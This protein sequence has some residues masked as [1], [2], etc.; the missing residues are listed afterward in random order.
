M[1][2]D[3]KSTMNR[4][5]YIGGS[6]IP[7]MLGL[8]WGC[9]RRLWYVKSGVDPDYEYTIQM[10]RAMTRGTKLETLA[11]ENMLEEYPHIRIHSRQKE[12]GDG[13]TIAH[14]DGIVEIDGE[15]GTLEIKCPASYVYRKYKTEGIPASYSAQAAYGAYL[16]G[17][18]FAVLYM[19][20]ADGWEGFPVTIPVDVGTMADIVAMARHFNEEMSDPERLDWSDDRCR[21]CRY[22]MTCWQGIDISQ[23][24][25][26]DDAHDELP[27]SH[28]DLIIEC[29]EQGKIASA[30]KA[31]EDEIKTMLKNDLKPGTYSGDDIL[32]R[33]KEIVSNR[34]DVKALKSA[35][36]EV[37][38]RYMRQ[39]R[40]ISCTIKG[41]S[42]D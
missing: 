15:S 29:A 36:P 7:D 2:T 22:R 10:E 31:R 40:S 27:A 1:S 3:K 33:I 37:A 21:R 28:R 14:V 42:Y 5:G 35:E 11:I 9:P 17:L 12:V 19:F 34:V 23:T 6:D 4:I 8:D 41:A 38:N 25:A 32:V 30:A 20:S 26:E 16:A 13:P 39:S 18:D 24:V